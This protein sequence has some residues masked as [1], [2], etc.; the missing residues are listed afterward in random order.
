MNET[1]KH[2]HE[3][4]KLLSEAMRE[5][6]GVIT[7]PVS[8]AVELKEYERAAVGRRGRA[9]PEDDARRICLRSRRILL[10]KGLRGL[11]LSIQ[12]GRAHPSVVRRNE[13]CALRG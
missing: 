4:L 12:E 8:L 3:Q 9:R 11:A 5:F 10:Y 2:T 7:L 1:K 6:G 13:R